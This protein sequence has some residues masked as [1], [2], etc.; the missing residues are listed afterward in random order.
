MLAK[1]RF[2]QVRQTAVLAGVHFMGD[3]CGVILLPNTFHVHFSS[4]RTLS[5]ARAWSVIGQAL[6]REKN[7][8]SR[9]KKQ[10]LAGCWIWVQNQGIP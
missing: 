6:G 9:D 10:V 7:G 3:T 2:Q 8:L 1:C 5:S 4:V